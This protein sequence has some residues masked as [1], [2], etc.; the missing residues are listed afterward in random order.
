MATIRIRRREKISFKCQS[1]RPEICIYNIK[2]IYISFLLKILSYFSSI[3]YV[4]IV[5]Y[6]F[7]VPY[8]SSYFHM[9]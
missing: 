1:R 7:Q 2:P 3:F 8:F 4:N 9:F 5:H 6:V